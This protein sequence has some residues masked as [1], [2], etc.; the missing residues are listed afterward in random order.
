VA[1]VALLVGLDSAA[2]RSRLESAGGAL[3]KALVSK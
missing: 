2:A 3:R 1:I